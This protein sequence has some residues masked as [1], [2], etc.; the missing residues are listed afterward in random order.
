MKWV[1]A[2]ALFAGIFLVAPQAVDGHAIL[3]EPPPRRGQAVGRG[4][5]FS[6]RPPTPAQLRTCMRAPANAPVRAYTAGQNV[7]IKWDITTPHPSNP[8][9][10]VSIKYRRGQKFRP[11]VTGVNI[12]R[13]SVTVSLPANETSEHAIM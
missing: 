6:P 1:H 12:F 9:V 2:A 8:G 13:R 10:T 4:L 11:L 5:K 3:T 7:T